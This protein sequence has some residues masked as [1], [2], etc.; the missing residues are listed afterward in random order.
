MISPGV[1]KEPLTAELFHC[2]SRSFPLPEIKPPPKRFKH[3]A[4]FRHINAT[5]SLSLHTDSYSAFLAARS[6]KDS[7]PTEA[8]SSANE[9]KYS[10]INP[11]NVRLS[12]YSDNLEQAAGTGFQSFP[13]ASS[14][15]LQP[16]CCILIFSKPFFFFLFAAT[17]ESGLCCIQV[18]QRANPHADKRAAANAAAADRAEVEEADSGERER[19]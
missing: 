15:K 13:V 19:S 1:H 6:K 8:V 10:V 18:V 12:A 2:R 4:E 11:V 16:N 14:A 3:H 5:R 9:N 7:T 17:Q